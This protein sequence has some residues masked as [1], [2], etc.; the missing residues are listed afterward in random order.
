MQNL[1]RQLVARG[2]QVTVVTLWQTGFE[3]FETD[4]D[5][6]IYRLHGLVQRLARRMYSNPQRWYVPPWPDPELTAGMRRVIGEEQPDVVH[7][8]NWMLH[9]FLPLKRRL[10]LP[11]AVT[12][13][14]Y[15]LRCAKWI[16]MYQDRPCNGPGAA[17]CWGCSLANYGLVKGAPTLAANWLSG[18]RERRLVDRFIPVSQAVAEGNALAEQGLPYEV[19]PN[20]LPD[21]ARSAAPMDVT[22]YVEQLPAEPY[23]LYVGAFGRHKGFGVLLE[24]MRPCRTGWARRPRRRWC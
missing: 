2:H 9:S 15:S 14:D 10:G 16:L 6:R 8:H 19:I 20:F 17:K 24:A 1:S 18:Y 13:H 22:A 7:A 5:I 23:L 11:L 12:L 3:E 4:G 21:P